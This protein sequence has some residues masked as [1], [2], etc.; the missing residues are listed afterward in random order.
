MRLR[1]TS[2]SSITPPTEKTQLLSEE[3]A[4]IEMLQ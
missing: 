1:A 2:H 3:E 4:D